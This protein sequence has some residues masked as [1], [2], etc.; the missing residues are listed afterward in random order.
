MV[1]APHQVLLVLAQIQPLIRLASAHHLQGNLIIR[2]LLLLHQE[3]TIR[4]PQQ[5]RGTR[6]H[7][8]AV[9]R[10]L[11][12]GVVN[13][14]DADAI[15]VSKLLQLSDYLIVAGIAVAVA[16][17]FPNFLQDIHNNKFGVTVFPDELFQLFIQATAIIL[18]LVAKCRELVPSTPNIRNIRRC[19]RLSSILQ[20][21]VENS[22]LMGL[23]APQVLPGTDMVGDLHHQEG[24]TDFGHSGKDVRSCIKQVLN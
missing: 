13:D 5:T 6:D 15:S 18:A 21:Q 11:L 24:L 2:P 7:L 20:R 3:C 1:K 19:K 23:V 10:R 14:Q 17:R 9:S 12:S 16:R 4:T 8:K 22:P